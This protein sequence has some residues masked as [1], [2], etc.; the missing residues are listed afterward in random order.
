[1]RRIR[2]SYRAPLACAL[3]DMLISD[4]LALSL[5]SNI[6]FVSYSALL[7]ILFMPSYPFKARATKDDDT[8]RSLCFAESFLF[9]H[10]CSRKAQYKRA[11][12]KLKA[13]IVE[14]DVRACPGCT[15]KGQGHRA[16]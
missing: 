12:D 2:C 14:A 4:F 16:S 1:M 3:S 8:E 7:A 5:S 6:L 15:P 9:E 11:V 13:S 10:S